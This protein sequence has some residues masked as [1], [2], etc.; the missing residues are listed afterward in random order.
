MIYIKSLIK[1]VLKPL[2]RINLIEMGTR[3]H[4]NFKIY[5]GFNRYIIRFIRFK[6]L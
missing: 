6:G 5:I 4:I 2:K 3:C 1:K